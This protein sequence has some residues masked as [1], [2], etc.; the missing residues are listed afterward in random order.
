[1]F[2]MVFRSMTKD[3]GVNAGLV[4]ELA[5]MY[6]HDRSSVD[7]QWRAYFDAL[8]GGGEVAV[9]SRARVAATAESMPP[10]SMKDRVDARKQAGVAQ[11]VEAYRAR[12]HLLAQIDPLGLLMLEAP[13][14]MLDFKLE[15]FGLSERDL[16]HEFQTVDMPGPPTAT[17]REIMARLQ[18]T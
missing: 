18:A 17:L 15:T 9:P 4:S 6:L 13:P 1:F 7:E 12:G 16:D 5:G 3:F 10:M 14:A 11:L 8:L 2:A